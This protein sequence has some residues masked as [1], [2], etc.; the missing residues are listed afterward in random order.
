MFPLH[1]NV[2]AAG[3]TDGIRANI[4]SALARTLPELV[5]AL[6]SHD[7][8]LVCVGS[9]PS[10]PSF[11]DAIKAER[12]RGRPILAVK[13]AHD[14]LCQQGVPPDLWICVDPRDRSN[15]LTE[16]NH[17]TTYLISSRCDPSMF[18]TLKDAH[19]ILIHCY[20]EEEPHPEFNGK[21]LLGGGSTSGLRGITAGYVMG[22]RNFILYGY[23]SCL[24]PDQQTKRF[25]GEAPD[26]K[27]LIDVIV[28]GRRFW[29]NGAL[30]Q[31]AKEFQD[32]YGVLE[33]F[34]V[35][36]HGDGLITAIV[37]ARAARGFQA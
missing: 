8:P 30:A 23:D 5:P 22:F 21:F 37:A 25:T 12:E 10:M 1:L 24:S 6:V 19:V 16:V 3:T 26:P 14:Y 20:A 35:E 9:G 29:C 31:Q 33:R 4:S 11:I 28:G 7:G 17:H 27:R 2:T 15:L 32:Y 18:E 13:G 34:H 36:S